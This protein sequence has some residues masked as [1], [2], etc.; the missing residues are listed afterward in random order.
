MSEE[1]YLFIR[2]SEY[3]PHLKIFSVDENGQK[4]YKDVI[5]ISARN[6]DIDIDFSLRS[7]L[8]TIKY[9]Q[10]EFSNGFLKVF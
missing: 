7:V 10:I 4:E 8:V 3:Y 9:K 2:L 5:N 1:K 6:T